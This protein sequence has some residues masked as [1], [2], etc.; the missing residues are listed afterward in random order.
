MERNIR[1]ELQAWKQ[2]PYRKPLIIRGARQVGKTYSILEFGNSYEG[3]VHQ[4]NFEKNPQFKNI[5]EEDLDANRIRLELETILNTDIVEN[6]DLLFFD[7][8]QSCPKAIMSL[9]YFYEQIPEIHIVAAG[10][11]L[12]FALNSISFPVGR[13]QFMELHPMS[14]SEYLRALSKHKIA[15]IINSEPKKVSQ[16]VHQTIIN[17]LF[18]YFFIGG[19]PEAVKYFRDYGKLSGVRDI[20]ESLIATYIQDFSKYSP[21]VDIDCLINVLISTAKSVGTQ[22]KYSKLSVGFSNPTIKKAFNALNR[23]RLISKV[24][25]SSVSGLPLEAGVNSKKFKSLFLDIGLMSHLNGMLNKY[26]DLKHNINS[27]FK[28][29]L[30]EQFVGQ[31]M[32]SNK[33]KQLY[34]WA[35]ETKSSTAEIDYL[36]EKKGKIIPVEVKSGSSGSLKSLHF[37]LET[38]PQIEESYIFSIAEYGKHNR[39][40]LHFI[41]IYYTAKMS[42]QD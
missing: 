6:V 13:V 34:Y 24:K 22:I 40:K 42:S 29:A 32:L 38:F 23:A 14:F 17:E 16:I 10:S 2:S 12:E 15:E 8:I 3:K 18:N 25:S 28:G 27:I 35:R 39:T 4:I 11:L 33:Q 7:E 5:F 20:H 30:A 21:T 36:L 9:R 26:V 31:E 41:P 1:N 19:M 37:L